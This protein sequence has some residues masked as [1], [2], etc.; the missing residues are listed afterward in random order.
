MSKNLDVAMAY[1][2]ALQAKD[3]EAIG[4]C[5]RDDIHFIGPLAN[6]TGRDSVLEG[7]K[8]LFPFFKNFN[9]RTQFESEDQVMVVYDLECS[10]PI[11]N[12]RVG[13]LLTFK[14]NLI[15][16]VELFFDARAFER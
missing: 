9:M 13:A 15:S 8:K 12:I 5:F 10:D 4:S 11:G 2:Q 14:Q 1:Y 3:L 7:V 16:V 6:L